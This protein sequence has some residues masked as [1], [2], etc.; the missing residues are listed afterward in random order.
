MSAQNN[1]NKPNNAEGGVNR[2]LNSEDTSI[3]FNTTTLRFLPLSKKEAIDYYTGICK[4]KLIGVNKN[5]FWFYGLMDFDGIISIAE[6]FWLEKE[7]YWFTGW[8]FWLI[9]LFNKNFGK[10]LSYTDPIM[11]IDREN[12]GRVFRDLFISENED[13]LADENKER[14]IKAII[15][16]VKFVD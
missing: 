5:S 2:S 11:E 15:P 6:Y 1:C 8:F 14:L 16:S 13:A 12:I 3:M 10:G 4:N 9:Q 7:H